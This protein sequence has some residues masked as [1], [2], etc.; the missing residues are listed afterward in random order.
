M[1]RWDNKSSNLQCGIEWHLSGKNFLNIKKVA[2]SMYQLININEYDN[3][4]ILAVKNF[5]VSCKIP[6]VD[7]Y[8]TYMS[9]AVFKNCIKRRAK[10]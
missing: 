6:M 2:N 9:D 4:G 5:L 1:G 3:K 8:V 10:I 7:T